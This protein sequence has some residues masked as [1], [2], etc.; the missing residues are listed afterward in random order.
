MLAHELCH[1]RRGDN[2]A[3]LFHLVVQTVFWFHPLVWWIGARLITERERACDEE[4][5]RHGS[6]R[7]TYAESILKTCQ[8]FVES[9][10]ACV[11]GVTGSDLKKR[12]EA[13]MT[14]DAGH[15][16]KHLEERHC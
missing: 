8:F 11:S 2:L 10:I 6:E 5:I 13:I 9:P 16:R 15:H 12:I 14:N 4:V 7:E 1:L 3:A